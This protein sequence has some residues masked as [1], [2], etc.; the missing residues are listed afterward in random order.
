MSSDILEY[1]SDGI[2]LGSS[3]IGVNMHHNNTATITIQNAHDNIATFNLYPTEDGVKNANIIIDAL[4]E[5]LDHI[6]P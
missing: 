1:I 5:W 3:Y 4:K 6:K 2:G